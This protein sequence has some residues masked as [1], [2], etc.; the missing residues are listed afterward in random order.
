MQVTGAKSVGRCGVVKF[1]PPHFGHLPVQVNVKGMFWLLD[2]PARDQII[3]HSITATKT[4]MNTSAIMYP[5]RV[6]G[7][8]AS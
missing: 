5:I 1:S 8:S 7:S 6:S 3:P 2:G 4:T